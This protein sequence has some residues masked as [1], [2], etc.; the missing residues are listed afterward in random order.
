MTYSVN[1]TNNSGAQ[2]NIAIFLSDA[3]DNSGFSLVWSL[4][5]IN[6]GGNYSFQ[7]DQNAFG[8][9]WGSSSLPIDASV[10]FNSGQSPTAVYPGVA[11]G[12]N[13]LPIQ[14]KS[15]SGFF[16]GSPYV[17]SS[18]YNKLEIT[19][20]TSF[21]VQNSLTMSVALYMGASP[22]LVIQGAPNTY[23]YFDLS[24]ISYYLTVTNLT[25]G[26]A[27]PKPNTNSNLLLKPTERTSISNPTKIEFSLGEPSLAY[28]LNETLTFKKI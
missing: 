1:V 11:G 21:T 3:S 16:S 13:G 18:L 8:L 2:Q 12:A 19:T 10:Q 27:L 22:A 14:Y 23:Y 6:D 4:R 24:Q 17:N 5:T 15:S 25:Q 20:D 26:S 9:G 28:I 7:W